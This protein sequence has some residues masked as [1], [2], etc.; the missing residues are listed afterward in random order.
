MSPRSA[1]IISD[2][3]PAFRTVV[4]GNSAAYKLFEKPKRVSDY[5]YRVG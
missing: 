4:L 3:F 5:T 1:K 2:I